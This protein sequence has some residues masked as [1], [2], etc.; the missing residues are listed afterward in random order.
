[1]P[2][3]QYIFLL[4]LF[5]LI[6][7][8]G[9]FYWLAL[10][11]KKR[12]ISK[13]GDP[14]LVQQLLAQYNPRS[15]FRK[16]LLVTIAVCLL[17]LA[18]ANLRIATGSEKVTRTGIDVMIALDVSKSMLAEDVQPTRLDRSKQLLGRLIDRLGNN[19]IGIVI[20]AGKA[21]L[22]M[23]L[24]GDL[25]AA[26]MYLSSATTQSVPTQG[27]VIGDALKMCYASFNAKEKK[28]KSVILISDG[29]DHDEQAEEVAKQMAAE[30]VVINTI[31]IGSAGG[32]PI[33]DLATGQMKTDM[34]GNM[35]VSRLNEAALQAIAT[36]GN[37]NYQLFKNTE[38]TVSMLARQLATM[39]Q[40]AVTEDSLVNYKSLSQIFL[41]LALAL[42]IWEMLISE[43]KTN[44][45]KVVKVAVSFALMLGGNAVFAQGEKALIKEGNDAY[46]KA[47][48]ATATGSY[49]KVVQKNPANA[50]AQYNLG[51]AL[52]KS[53]K[54]EEA[55]ASYDRAITQLNKPIQKSNAFYNKGVVLHNNKKI[56]ECIIAYKEAL[57]LDPNNEDAR[58]NL[59]KALK[60]QKEDQKKDKDQDKND[61][62]QK[63][64]D[65]QQPK[66]QQSRISK[67]DAEEKL[68]ALLQKEKNLQD[69]LR[70]VNSAA[71]DRP[72]KDW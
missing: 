22:Q 35:V 60:Q 16:F 70:K 32:A 11:K 26:K 49:A 58:Q 62:D 41:A 57:K 1:M 9:L 46:K 17:I 27:T 3:F 18:I 50:T 8:M 56:P 64:K 23:P 52:Y 21:Y 10:R 25:A 61:Q 28:Y 48:Y 54:T 2:Q 33:R 63:N 39:D 5:V 31:G 19:R 66:P 4:F 34:Q 13:M 40:R 69:K 47:D 55:I 43:M 71:P 37:G 24:T 67:K 30:G 59:Q 44:K 53:Q 45:T 6:P 51:N 20:F 72:E 38:E 42:L 7:L 29:E 36:S 68:K 12:S 15:Y 14:E 65:E